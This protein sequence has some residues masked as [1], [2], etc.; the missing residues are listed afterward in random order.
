MLYETKNGYNIYILPKIVNKRMSFPE[1]VEVCKTMSRS[2]KEEGLYATLVIEN[3][4]YQD[5]L[6]QQLK[7]E[8][9]WDV[10]TVRPGHSDKRSRLMLTSNLIKDGRVR[11][12]RT[13]AEQLIEQIVHFGVEKHD[14]LA[15]A[16]SSLVLCTLEDPPVVPRIFFLNI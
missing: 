2:Y 12:P 15:D 16:F 9:I 8:G 7:E 3:V 6:P 14:D 10:K 5:A 11:F 4:A 13:G 1:T